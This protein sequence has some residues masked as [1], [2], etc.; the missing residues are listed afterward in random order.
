MAALTVTSLTEANVSGN[1]TW[2]TVT[3]DQADT[4]DLSTIESERFVILINNSST[5]AGTATF[6]DGGL[7]EDSALGDLAVTIPASGNVALTLESSRFKDSGDDVT[8]TA[9][10]TGS[11]TSTLAAISLP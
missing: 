4:I 8:I 11:M 7:Y 5:I 6:S 10:S 3:L 1:V 2:N 9:T